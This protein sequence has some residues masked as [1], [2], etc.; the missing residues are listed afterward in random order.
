MAGN[1]DGV[2]GASV[3]D[4]DDDA[5]TAKGKRRKSKK[6]LP[7]RVGE[8]VCLGDLEDSITSVTVVPMMTM[9]YYPSGQCKGGR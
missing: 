3:E 1:D 8:M 6:G 9:M 4:Y 2:R 5:G 7:C